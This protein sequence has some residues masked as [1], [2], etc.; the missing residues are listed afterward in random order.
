MTTVRRRS[1]R[2]G[3][4]LVRLV[5]RYV[6]AVLCG[7]LAVVAYTF[8]TGGGW[9]ETWKYLAVSAFVVLVVLWLQRLTEPREK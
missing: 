8:A 9:S 3:G 7:W 5:V 2:K 4:D 1:V 6:A